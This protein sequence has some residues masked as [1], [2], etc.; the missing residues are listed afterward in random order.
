MILVRRFFASRTFN[1]F[2]TAT[3]T[4]FAEEATVKDSLLLMN[5]ANRHLDS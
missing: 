2:G 4:S 1:P 5:P 3:G